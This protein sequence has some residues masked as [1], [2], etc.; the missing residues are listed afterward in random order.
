VGRLP[1][2]TFIGELE[3]SNLAVDEDGQLR[4]SGVLFGKA[5]VNGVT[6]TIGQTFT[7][8]GVELLQAGQPNVCD[9]LI[10]D[11]DPIHVDQL[12]LDVDLSR[13]TLNSTAPQ[14]RGYLLGRFLCPLAGLLNSSSPNL[15]VIQQLLDAI[16]ELL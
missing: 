8:V 4:A 3:S 13:I 10:L 5:T 11:F 2:G 16:N 14:S 7:D 15:T 1:Q 6:Q 12:D 9:I